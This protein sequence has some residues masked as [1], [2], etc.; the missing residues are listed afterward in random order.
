M[1]KQLIILLTLIIVSCVGHST[2][3]H[4]DT[5][6]QGTKQIH[7]LDNKGKKHFIGSIDFSTK[8]ATIHYNID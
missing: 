5:F 3:V 8:E 2:L 1:Y 4:A 6:Y 7:L